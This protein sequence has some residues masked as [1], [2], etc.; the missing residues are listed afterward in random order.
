MHKAS[1]I[2]L[3]I[4]LLGFIGPAFPATVF[5]QETVPNNVSTVSVEQRLQ[6]FS[7]QLS[8]EPVDARVDRVWHLIPGLAGWA[9]IE[10]ESMRATKEAHDGKIHLVWRQVPPKISAASLGAEPIYRAPDAEKSISLMV[11]VSWGE[12]YVPAMLKILRSSHVHATFFLD[13][14]WVKEHPD[15]VKAMVQD[16]HAIGSHGSGHPDFRKLTNA[17]LERQLDGTNAIIENIT[18]RKVTAIAP[19]SGSYDNRLVKMTK[20]RKTYTIMW[21]AD[22]VDWRRPPA[23]VIVARAKRGL[24]PGCLL[25]MHPTK[26]T[27]EALP[28]I[29]KLIEANGYHAK[30]IDDVIAER[31]SVQPPSVLS[32]VQ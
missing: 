12:E 19:P 32:G 26:S 28:Q 24:T 13:G 18:H 3:S 1:I 22:T 27:V 6:Q 17:G 4:T 16:G 20:A 30:T 11:N 10:D 25:L 15:L 29:I 9:L 5:A 8:K 14:K 23:E 21:T 2:T 31:P 7:K